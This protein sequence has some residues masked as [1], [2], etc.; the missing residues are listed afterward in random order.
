MQLAYQLLISAVTLLTMVSN[1]PDAS[2]DLKAR[3]TLIANQAIT[4][5]QGVIQN[6]SSETVLQAQNTTTPVFGS[7]QASPQVSPAPTCTLVGEVYRDNYN[8]FLGKIS[9][10]TANAKTGY[11]INVTNKNTRISQNMQDDYYISGS[12]VGSTISSGFFKSLSLLNDTDFTAHVFGDGGEGICST[13][14]SI[15]KQDRYDQCMDNQKGVD[16]EYAK[17]QCNIEVQ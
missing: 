2:A 5:A 17:G 8:N 10:N 14:I 11:I 16:L 12:L 3:A 15:S 4:Y 1:S 7:I 6:Q 13:R 9:W